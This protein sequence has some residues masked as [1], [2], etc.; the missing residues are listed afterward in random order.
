MPGAEF[1]EPETPGSQNVGGGNFRVVE[2]TSV[3]GSTARLVETIRG[4]GT[5]DEGW[6]SLCDACGSPGTIEGRKLK[7]CSR[8]RT[9]SY[10]SHE[11]QKARWLKHKKY[12]RAA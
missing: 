8:C 1:A 10:C 5:A 11:C 4:K 7:K 3:P 12:C 6:E 2:E 9:V